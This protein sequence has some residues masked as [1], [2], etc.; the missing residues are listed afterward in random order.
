[1]GIFILLAAGLLISGWLY[2]GGRN[3]ITSVLAGLCTGGVMGSFGMPAGPIMVIY[4]MSAPVEP[5]VQRANI[6]I[7]VGVVLLFMMGG[8]YFNGAY[9]KSTVARAVV[10][11]PIFMAG[12]W[13]GSYLFR[14]APVSWFKKVTCLTSAPMAPINRI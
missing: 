6:I 13:S 1:M 10:I 8:L 4:Y 12:A 5:Q 14:I 3:K 7:S 2:K 9:H 11:T